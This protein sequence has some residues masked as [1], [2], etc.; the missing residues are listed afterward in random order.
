MSLPFT[1]DQFLD[2]FRRYNLAVWPAQEVLVTLGVVA[3]ALAAY[4]RGASSRWVSAILAL[5]WLW[6]AAV[7]HLAFFSAINRAALL[8][9]AAFALQGALF[10]WM[11][12]RDPSISYRPQ[13][14]L[15]ATL[16]IVILTYALLVY[17]T[18][19]DAF[20]HRYPAAPTFGVPC[21]TTIF[22][23]GLAV[24]AGRSLPRRALIVP[25]AWSLVAVSAAT[26]LGMIEDFGLPV[27]AIAVLI[28]VPLRRQPAP[29]VAT[30]RV[31]AP[32]PH[33]AYTDPGRSAPLRPR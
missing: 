4:G 1:V 25:L 28:L 14:I 6:M 19:G 11:A 22:T 30:E 15:T 29:N 2:V 27:A 20:G 23:L 3:V 16:G 8:F 31:A 17:P 10:A 21:P 5:L 32:A 18:L 12:I 33:H 9:A 24:W 7:Y 26:N 13:S